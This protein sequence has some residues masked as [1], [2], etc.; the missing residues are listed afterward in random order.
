M[1]TSLESVIKFW[2]EDIRNIPG[3]ENC[4]K[5]FFLTVT[6]LLQPVANAPHLRH[7]SIVFPG[8]KSVG[9]LKRTLHHILGES[10]LQIAIGPGQPCVRT[11]C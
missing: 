1:K 10:L 4:V 7:S 9:E 5:Y 3:S 11:V 2:N 8:H 6:I